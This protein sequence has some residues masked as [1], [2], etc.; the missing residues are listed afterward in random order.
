[1]LASHIFRDGEIIILLLKPSAWFIPWSSLTFC[2]AV[3]LISLGT[4]VIDHRT[5]DRL[6]F[7]LA[8]V[9]IVGRLV[10]ALL[11]WMGRLYVLTDQRI[12]RLA[13]VF[14]IDV[15]DCPLRKSCGRD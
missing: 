7:E 4:A 8:T 2:G 12:L 5:H 9:F 13:G 1:M 6:D 15:F 10:W 14:Y 11:Q 3:M